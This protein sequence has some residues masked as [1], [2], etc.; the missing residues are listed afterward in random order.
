MS[1]LSPQ[2]DAGSVNVMN[3]VS[4]RTETIR[5]LY[6]QTR[7]AHGL[8]QTMLDAPGPH[9]PQLRRAERMLRE[10]TVAMSASLSI[11]MIRDAIA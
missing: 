5:G 8:V 6:D 10:A 3:E 11:S 2:G 1:V 7:E 9:D 4:Q